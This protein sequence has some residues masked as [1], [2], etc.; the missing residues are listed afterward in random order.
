[1]PRE[2]ASEVAQS[3]IRFVIA[4]L[5]CIYVF[6]F[7]F[8]FDGSGA[9][10]AWAKAILLLYAIFGVLATILHV[11]IIL[12]PG[13]FP[14]RRLISMALD[15]GFTA[16][17]IIIEPVKMM[18]L[19]TII[20][21]VTVGNGLRF[22][23]T[24][25]WIATGMAALA[26]AFV[27]ESI[28]S[29]PDK[30]FLSIM[31]LMM[32]V[33]I[34]HYATALLAR[35]E[36]ARREADAANAGKLRFLAEASHDLRQ[37]LHAINLF[38]VSLHQTGLNENQRAIVDRIDRALQ[39][40][41][42]LFRSLLDMSKL[43]SGSL[44][45]VIEPVHLGELLSDVVQQNLQ[46]AE[47]NGT[48][49]RLVD[50]DR[51]VL[52]DQALLGTMVQNLVSNA[53]KHSAGRGVVL[54][55]RRSRGLLAIE[56]WDQGE[57][58]SEDHL[59]KLFDEFYQVRKRGDPDRQGVGLG[60]SIVKRLA[61]LLSLEISVRSQPGKGTM[62]RLG[63]L[64]ASDSRSKINRSTDA[65]V[66]TVRLS[67]L[68]VLLVEDDPDILSATAGLLRGWGC[69]VIPWPNIVTNILE[70][71]PDCDLLITDLDLGDGNT[72]GDCIEIVRSSKGSDLPA[73]VVTGHDDQRIG[74]DI[75][76]K[77]VI[78][79]RKP[80]RPAELRSVIGS[81]KAGRTVAR[82]AAHNRY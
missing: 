24:Y 21:W 62:F 26:I 39:S 45:P 10:A 78:V 81:I 55:C 64:M 34:P 6:F 82:S 51:V 8:D 37:P 42:R 18:P 22:G 11:W 20:L 74:Q 9:L 35:I 33:L 46:S 59:P 30:L 70:D 76:G 75:G 25:M 71:I 17:G 31:L 36:N 69:Q 15:F 27:Q 63:G 48:D 40:V 47:W 73:I 2:E 13:H 12:Q 3:K 32:V 44:N 41:A 4:S 28:P 16:F 66:D 80:L 1:M 7:G 56:V 57:G 52:T 77:G 23:T 5:V 14:V 29:D 54:G 49:L 61:E 68:T 38:T 58:I 72:G 67:G 60:L 79:L 43:D 65:P 50:C 19:Y 53:I